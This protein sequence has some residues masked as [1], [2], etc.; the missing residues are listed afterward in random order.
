MRFPVAARMPGEQPVAQEVSN[1]RGT[2][3]KRRLVIGCGY[4]GRRVAELWRQ[5]GDEVWALSREGSRKAELSEAGIGLLLGDVTDPRQLPAFPE[6]DTLLFCISYR[7]G[8]HAS[9]R[10]VYVDG[11]RNVLA[12]LAGVPG[13]VAFASSTG[14]YGETGGAEVD[15]SAPTRPTRESPQALLDAET[16]L[17]AEPW[18][19]RR[20]VFRL[21]GLYGPG[22]ITLAAKLRR[23]EPLPTDPDALLNLVHVDD[24]ARLI[25]EAVDRLAPPGV[26][27]V[28][29]G[30]PVT[31]REFY[32]VLADLLGCPPPQ[33]A[34]SQSSGRR[35]GDKRVVSGRILRELGGN[36]LHPNYAA[37]LQHAVRA[38]PTL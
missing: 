35:G 7:Y 34:P 8:Q 11:L 3:V 21:A 36:L 13:V 1:E 15:E 24:A 31:R 6:V 2:S 12:G 5:A 23:G 25:A 18:A 26:Y 17:E 30:Q 20:L 32:A 4:L 28:S 27:N 16:L 10:A 38:E 33:F 29:D 9:P 37:G 14:V 22:R 19:P